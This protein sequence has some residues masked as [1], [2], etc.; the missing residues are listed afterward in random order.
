MPERKAA[1]N[2]RPFEQDEK[3]FFFFCSPST[4]LWLLRSLNSFHGKLNWLAAALCAKKMLKLELDEHCC[5]KNKFRNTFIWWIESGVRAI[6]E[7]PPRNNSRSKMFAFD[8]N[9][10]L[11]NPWI[12]FLR[13]MKCKRRISIRNQT[14]FFPSALRIQFVLAL[15]R[16]S[17]ACSRRTPEFH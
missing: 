4:T 8:F 11:E 14:L 3:T 12:M 10:M 5:R 6:A 16:R 7:E 2:F 1:T 13:L 9:S 17:A 15:A